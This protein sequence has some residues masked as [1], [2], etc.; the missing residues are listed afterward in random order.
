MLGLGFVPVGVRIS[1]W[2]LRVW[3]KPVTIVSKSIM[4]TIHSTQLGPHTLVGEYMF[5]FRRKPWVAHGSYL[6]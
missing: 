6:A 2:S 1:V 5:I 4:A 3:P